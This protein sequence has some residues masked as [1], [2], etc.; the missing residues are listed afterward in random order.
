VDWDFVA[1]WPEVFC[2]LHTTVV[3]YIGHLEV[4]KERAQDLKNPR[5][6]ND[7]GRKPDF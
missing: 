3:E 2:N 7:G 4:A 6:V 5:N 1:L